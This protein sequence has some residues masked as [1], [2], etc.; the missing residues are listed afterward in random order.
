M[1]TE[2]IP[3]PLYGSFEDFTKT[4]PNIVDVNSPEGL[5]IC[6]NGPITSRTFYRPTSEGNSFVPTGELR[7]GSL[8]GYHWPNSIAIFT[9]SNIDY[10]DYD[11]NRRFRPQIRFRYTWPPSN[12]SDSSAEF[13][14]LAD[15][16]TLWVW[17]QFNIPGEPELVVYGYGSGQEERMVKD[18]LGRRPPSPRAQSIQDEKSGYR[19]SANANFYSY[20]FLKDGIFSSRLVIPRP[21]RPKEIFDNLVPQEL[22]DN[23][24]IQSSSL[25]HLW[26][27]ANLY[28]ATG[29]KSEPINLPYR[30]LRFSSLTDLN[31]LVEQEELEQDY[32]EEK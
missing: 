14:D 25:D 24:S 1:S 30:K 5:V 32:W 20:I 29:I 21:I 11:T 19:M 10:Q 4:L 8:Y 28:I 16:N 27:N 18:N 7:I 15:K 17:I 2:K 3:P 26:R 31:S 12:D 6:K 23:P 22:V 9:D 13:E